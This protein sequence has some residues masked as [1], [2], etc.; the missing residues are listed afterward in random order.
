[1]LHECFSRTHLHEPHGRQRGFDAGR[2]GQNDPAV[3]QAQMLDHVRVL[4]TGYF[5]FFFFFFFAAGSIAGVFSNHVFASSITTV[6]WPLDGPSM[7]RF[8]AA[9]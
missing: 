8:P 7:S 2:A 9:D 3:V 5:S 4:E 6:A 1:M